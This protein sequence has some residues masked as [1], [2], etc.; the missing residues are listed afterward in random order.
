MTFGVCFVLP[1]T[2]LALHRTTWEHIAEDK[3][4]ESN[5]NI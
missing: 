4:F 2:H 3:G 1:N 5:L